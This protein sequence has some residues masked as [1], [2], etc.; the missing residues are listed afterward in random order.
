MQDVI[1]PKED[2]TSLGVQSQYFMGA[3]EIFFCS[4]SIAVFE[5]RR[6]LSQMGHHIKQFR[7]MIAL[8]E[9]F[10]ARFLFAINKRFQSW[11]NKYK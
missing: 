9:W 3:V 1:V 8:N 10:A 5:M 11:L 2:Y 6:L 7:D 4:E